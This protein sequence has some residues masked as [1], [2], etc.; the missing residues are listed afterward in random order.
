MTSL[1]LNPSSTA[2]W[3]DLVQDA[4]QITENKLNETLESYL[5][6]LLMR[7]TNK[8]EIAST[9]LALDYLNSLLESKHNRREQ[10]RNIGD[11]CLLFSGLFP[12]RAERKRV[13]ISYFVHL[14]RNAYSE[15]AHVDNK[16]TAH[17][18]DDLS[19]GFIQLMDTLHAIRKLGNNHPDLSPFQAY[20][21]WLETGSP[22]AAKSVASQNNNSTIMV[23]EDIKSH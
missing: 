6:F 21:L 17:I 2:Q 23:H 4:Q 19:Q 15:L 7:F 5:V 16:K 10:L 9:V 20:D 3:H 8:P 12:Q 11:Q 18:Y 1:V 22:M 13:K 14:G